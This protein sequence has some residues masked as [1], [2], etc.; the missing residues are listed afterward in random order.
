VGFS[1]DSPPVSKG[2]PGV[3]P[4]LLPVF[5]S[6]SS[7]YVR[8]CACARGEF[9]ASSCSA[10]ADRFPQ[11]FGGEISVSS[12]ITSFFSRDCLL[13]LVLLLEKKIQ[14][15]NGGDRMRELLAICLRLY[16]CL[17]QRRTSKFRDRAIFLFWQCFYF[18]FL[19]VNFIE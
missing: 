4:P 17:L 6:S 8:V 12:Y 2:R 10:A 3:T 19:Q 9:C 5:V 18:T 11:N 13:F 7:F 15:M 16:L 1:S 14:G